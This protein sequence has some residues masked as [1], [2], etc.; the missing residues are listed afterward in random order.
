M[1]GKTGYQTQNNLTPTGTKWLKQVLNQNQN[2][3]N[4]TLGDVAFGL[5][6]KSKAGK[7]LQVVFWVNNLFT[8]VLKWYLNRHGVRG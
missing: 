1:A 3:V 7:D 8:K 6:P 2:Y 5:N 4:E